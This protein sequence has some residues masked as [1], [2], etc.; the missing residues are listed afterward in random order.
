MVKR[1]TAAGVLAAADRFRRVK[2]YREM[3]ALCAAL[4]AI[5]IDE[6]HEAA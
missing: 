3:N 4:A 5:R 2:G 1:W 6:K